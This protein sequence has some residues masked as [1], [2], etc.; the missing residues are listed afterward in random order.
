MR[1]CRLLVVLSMLLCGCASTSTQI[2]TEVARIRHLTVPESGV[3][4]DVSVFLASKGAYLTGLPADSSWPENTWVKYVPGANWPSQLPPPVLSVGR[5][6]ERLKSSA[7]LEFLS[8]EPDIRD[9]RLN[10]VKYENSPSGML[11]SVNKKLLVPAASYSPGNKT[12]DVVMDYPGFTGKEIYGV[13]DTSV[14]TGRRLASGISGIMTVGSFDSNSAKLQLVDGKIPESPVFILL[15]AQSDPVFEVEIQVY[16]LDKTLD[17]AV[18]QEIQSWLAHSLPGM[19]KISVHKQTRR[20]TNRD[21]ERELGGVQTEKLEVRLFAEDGVFYMRDQG[22]R[23]MSPGGSAYT[24]VVDSNDEKSASLLAISALMQSLQMLGNVGAAI[25]IGEQAYQSETEILGRAAIAPALARSYHD[26][27]RDDWAL[28]LALEL[29]GYAAYVEG[30]EK[31]KLMASIAAVASISGRASEF[32][33]AFDEVKQH[34][35]DLTVPWLRV[36]SVAAMMVDEFNGDEEYLQTARLYLNRHNGWLLEDEMRLCEFESEDEDICD[37]GKTH[38]NSQFSKVWF[39]SV[40]ARHHED[41]SAMLEIAPKLDEV[42]APWSAFQLWM[43]LAT[44]HDKPDGVAEIWLNAAA[45]ARCTQ[46]I[47]VYLSMM[48]ALH[49][50]VE[51]R[52]LGNL[53]DISVFTEALNLWRTLDMRSQL[54]SVSVMHAQQLVPGERLDL[55]NY[56]LALYQSIGDIDNIRIVYDMLADTAEDAGLLDLSIQYENQAK[57]FGFSKQLNHTDDR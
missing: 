37:S 50:F 27:D 17:K 46:Q 36:F 19:D 38:A 12:I 48:D 44:L 29:S 53:L 45:Y 1:R 20:T 22:L 23:V 7:R 13:W 11:D 2:P 25:W 54:A 31:T 47:R 16:N 18:I 39:D 35:S 21:S 33:D 9:D 14:S 4:G 40:I 5:V 30:K 41:I 26:I 52:Q 10:V 56:A 32:R 28:E 34:I 3:S 8:L 15:D 55:L 6:T 43:Q 49:R 57:E 51:A 24:V 42:G